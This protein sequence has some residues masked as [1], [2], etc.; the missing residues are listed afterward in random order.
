MAKIRN[1]TNSIDL[2]SRCLIKHH[3]MAESDA[4]SKRRSKA[5]SSIVSVGDMEHAGF[6]AFVEYSFLPRTDS[7]GVVSRHEEDDQTCR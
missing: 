6:Q 7:R 2:S 5:S 4:S 3:S 1:S